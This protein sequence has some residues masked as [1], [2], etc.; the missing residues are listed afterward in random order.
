MDDGAENPA[1]LDRRHVAAADRATIRPF[2]EGR[3]EPG[4][5]FYSDDAAAVEGIPDMFNRL[6]HEA[7]N[8]SVG[9]YVRGDAHTN[10]VEPFRSMLKRGYRGVYRRM[11]AKHLQRCVTGFAGRHNVRGMG[12]KRL[13]WKESIA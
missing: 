6:H 1:G 3:V 4:S 2:V 8:H 13:P 11:S 12:G 9:E 10:G 7:M 5:T